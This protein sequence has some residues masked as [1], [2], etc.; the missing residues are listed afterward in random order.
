MKTFLVGYFGEEKVVIYLQNNHYQII[1]R[2]FRKKWGEIDIVAKDKKTKE[3]VFIEVKTRQFNSYNGLMPEEALTVKKIYRLK[4]V[5]LSYLNQYNLEEN[6]WRFDFIAVEIN[7]FSQKSRIR[8]YKD[9][10]LEF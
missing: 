6:S 5:F 10:F 4:R 8:H 2:N 9:V 1:Q 3:I 7:N